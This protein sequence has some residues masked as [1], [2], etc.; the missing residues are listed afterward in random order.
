MPPGR[1]WVV[2]GAVHSVAGGLPLPWL[3]QHAGPMSPF[4]SRALRQAPLPADAE[5]LLATA[6]SDGDRQAREELICSGLRLVVLHA[7]R[8]G[9]RGEALEEAVAAGAEAL[10]RAVDR[11]DP[12]RGTRL[13]TYAW[14]WI[15]RAMTPQRQDAIGPAEPVGWTDDL[16][17]DLPEDWA[18]ILGLR[19]GFHCEDGRGLTLAEVAMELGCS[20]W[21]VRD[22]E[23]KALSHLRGR[24]ATVG[25]RAPL[26]GA[27]P[28]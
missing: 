6:A 20:V 24:L 8:L 10:V 17:S 1:L 25:R 22:V 13:A 23:A 5:F 9:H 26:A 4:V 15:S 7:L 12:A 21:Q 27:D 19:F 16:L 14:Q 18:A 11:F 28:P 3:R 2:P